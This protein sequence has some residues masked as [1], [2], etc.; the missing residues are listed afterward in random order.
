[1]KGNKNKTSNKYIKI[2]LLTLLIIAS[3]LSMYLVTNT[4]NKVFNAKII[5]QKATNEREGYREVVNILDQDLKN[6]L[7][8]YF[9]K[10]DNERKDR[11]NDY[12]LKL[13][14][15][16]YIKPSDENEIYRDEMEKILE[17]RISNINTKEIP[18]DLTG[19]EK[20]I[21]LRK[22]EL[23]GNKI[24]NI[25]PLRGLT[26]LT[27]L[28]LHYNKLENIELLRGLTSLT[29]LSLNRN[30]IENI[31]PLKG[32]TN[33]T[34]LYLN[35]NKIENIEPLKGLTN[36]KYLSLENNKI[37]NIEPLKGLT[38]L[39]SLNLEN[40]KI[41]NIEPL[42]GLTTLTGL[43]LSTNKI[44]NIEPLKVLTNLITLY[45][46]NNKIENI[47]VLKGLTNLTRL[48]LYHEEINVSPNTNK[49]N[50]PVLK[51]YNGEILDIVQASNGLLRK[52][53]DE[54][55]SFTREVTEVQTVNVGIGIFSEDPKT[56]AN[57][58]ANDPIYILKIDPQN[59]QREV[60]NIPDQDLKNFLLKY[61]KKP[62]NERKKN[63][64]EYYLKLSNTNYIKPSN[65][66]EIYKD[67]ME[68]I[69][70]LR[71]E[72]INKKETAMDLTG[73]E[74]AINL[75]YLN[76][77]LNKIENVE[78]LK[79]LTSLTQLYLGYNKIENIEPLRELTNLTSLYLGTNKIENV[80]PLRGLTNL[81]Y[82]SLEQNKIENIEP[83]MGLTKLTDLHLEQNKIENIEPLRGLTNLKYLFL[84]NN[85][86]ENIEPLKGLTSLMRLFLTINKIE[87]IEPLKGLTSLTELNLVDNKIENIEPLKGLTN[88]ATLYLNDN[89]IENIEPLKGLTSLTE[90]GLSNNKIYNIEPLKGLTNGTRLGLDY[91]EI[92]VS[93][94]TNKFNLPVLKK[95]N[96][97][98]L[99]IVKASKGLLKKNEDGT[100]SF[101]RK[102]TGTQIVNVGTGISTKD[103]K[104]DAN[105]NANVLYILKIDP[106][107][108]VDEKVSITKTI[109]DKSNTLLNNDKETKVLPVIKRNGQV[110]THANTNNVGHRANS[111]ELLTYTW[112]ELP[113]F[114]N[115]YTDYNYEVTF[116]IS[117]LPEGYSIVPNT[118]TADN[119]A[120]FNITYVSP[121]VTVNKEIT[122]NGGNKDVLPNEIDVRIENNRGLSSINKKARLNTEKTAYVVSESLD[123]TT[124]SADEITYTVVP[125]TEIANYT[126]TNES[127]TY[128]S[129][130]GEFRNTIL[131]NGGNKNTLPNQIDVKI[132]N[133]KNQPEKTVKAN[134][135]ADKSGYEIT[136]NLPQTTNTG[137]HISYS[138]EPLT[139]LTNYVLD[140]GNYRY[141]TPR[142][143]ITVEKN[144]VNGE[145]VRP[146]TIT[147]K[148]KR[149]ITSDNTYTFVQDVTVR[150]DN[151]WRLVVS[152]LEKTDTNGND[153]TYI[154]EEETNVN[155]FNPS[156]SGL[157][158]TN[159]YVITKENKKLTVNV[160]GG[161][162][163]TLPQNIQVTIKN[164]KGIAEKVVNATLNREK[165]AYEVTENLDTTKPNGERINYTVSPKT[166]ITNY[167]KDVVGENG[168]SYVIPKI[169]FEKTINKNGGKEISLIV[170]LKKNGV[171]VTPEKSVT[172]NSGETA[173]FTDLDKTDFDGNENTYSVEVVP[174]GN[175]PEGYSINTKPN[176]DVEVLYTS[177]KTSVTKDITVNRWR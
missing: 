114:D 84:E 171:V 14:N 168:Y 64:Y 7:L 56:D 91:E 154:V 47:E 101:T 85:K 66:N 141:V 136:E 139:Q 117:G 96:G 176:G 164:D 78:P 120:D 53:S 156:Y 50:L 26:N 142:I 73:L 144:W 72:I 166:D 163:E 126:K 5:N 39:T 92:N 112:N 155:G 62:D 52:N 127:Y 99:D 88:L 58:N 122:V 13:S 79:G 9:K 152:N 118:K 61:F 161:N 20:A 25:E 167:E 146:E 170:K 121:K 137:E 87:N 83:L 57:W 174:N 108:I 43:S 98:I 28:Y 125:V 46:S 6:F 131:V 34:S 60:V 175:L 177:P 2:M 42:K 70:E 100:Y 86:I 27:I 54:T 68:K 74:K 44:E 63:S 147:A 128:V 135:K 145:T 123:K 153:Y 18:L 138:I 10:P 35:D 160:N 89:K 30:K 113:K 49:F 19:L 80:E 4:N 111:D 172:I 103:P 173:R 162:K 16:N 24:E 59:I 132:K 105:W 65:E 130:K 12:Y 81:K 31:E 129:P 90:L 169:N 1:M 115:T 158:I 17:L 119:Q 67:E 143:N 109:K 97:D 124:T 93:P 104:V 45:L 77:G 41:E 37:E 82:L 15:T 149:K 69:L 55:Y 94:T 159:T 140:N 75:R 33:L 76:L 32:L 110:I 157:T 102:V 151:N 148:L 3:I 106:T 150:K 36:L 40:N 23:D 133:D 11:Y 116:D 48:D 29:S 21:N 134:L 165:T 8:K 38:N 95:Y 51:K 107:N 71:A 22:L